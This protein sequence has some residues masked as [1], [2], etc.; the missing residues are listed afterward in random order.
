[1]LE[2]LKEEYNFH[3]NEIQRYEDNS[4]HWLA[5]LDERLGLI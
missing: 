1:M 5:R 3:M 2:E 4:D